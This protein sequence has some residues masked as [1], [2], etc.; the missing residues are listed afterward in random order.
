[1]FSAVMAKLDLPMYEVRPFV[2]KPADGS[3]TEYYSI[4][5]KGPFRW[6]EA[7]KGEAGLAQACANAGG[8]RGVP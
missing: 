5:N 2:Y 1:M 8:V 3:S 4:K 6:R 7:E